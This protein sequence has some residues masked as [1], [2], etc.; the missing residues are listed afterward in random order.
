[1]DSLVD[2]IYHLKNRDKIR[3]AVLHDNIGT[4]C[5]AEKMIEGHAV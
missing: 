4:I 3:L 1:M 5:S 2:I